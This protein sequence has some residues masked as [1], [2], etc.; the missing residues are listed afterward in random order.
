MRQELPTR[1]GSS[2]AALLAMLG[3]S[4][5]AGSAGVVGNSC[6]VRRRVPLVPRVAGVC[7]GRQELPT[8]GCRGRRCSGVRVLAG[9]VG[10]SCPVR[11]WVAPVPRVAGVRDGRQEL[12]TR[13]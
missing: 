10:N 9:P 8:R 13:E 6:F 11:R 3:V 4:V 12:P 1:A 7:D 2:G 5:L